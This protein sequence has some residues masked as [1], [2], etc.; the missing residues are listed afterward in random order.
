MC[1]KQKEWDCEKLD[2]EE[3]GTYCGICT[4]GGRDHTGKPHTGGMFI[5]PIY[6]QII[7]EAAAAKGVE[8]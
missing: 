1:E 3:F 2:E 6:K 7:D 5:D 4:K 8:A